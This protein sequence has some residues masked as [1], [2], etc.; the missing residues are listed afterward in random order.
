[1][2]VPAIGREVAL[3]DAREYPDVMQPNLLSPSEARGQT[4]GPDVFPYGRTDTTSHWPDATGPADCPDC[5]AVAID[6]QGIQDCP[7]CQWT[8]HGDGR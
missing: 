4:S 5:G 6:V 1:M 3:F 7:D 2:A 8:S